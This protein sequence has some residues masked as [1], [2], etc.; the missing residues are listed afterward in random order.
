MKIPKKYLTIIPSIA[1]LSQRRFINEN[2][3][4]IPDHNTVYRGIIAAEIHQ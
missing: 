1:V 4:K 3:K 2:T